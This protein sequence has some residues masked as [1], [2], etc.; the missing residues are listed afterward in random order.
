MSDVAK[1][2]FCEKYFDSTFTV[3]KCPRCSADLTG[4]EIKSESSSKV[5][6]SPEEAAHIETYMLL[7]C[8]SFLFCGCLG[9][10]A[11]IF[12]ILSMRAKG[13][14]DVTSAESNAHIAKILAIVSIVFGVL[15]IIGRLS[16][17]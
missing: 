17:R 9:L 6:A 7:S 10:F 11:V 15:S 8:I 4:V 2:P 14:G 1:C 3:E 13:R 16:T 12:S 5:Y